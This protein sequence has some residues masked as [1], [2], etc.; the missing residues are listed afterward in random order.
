M[1]IQQNVENKYTQMHGI[2]SPFNGLD[3]VFIS[4]NLDILLL[5]VMN[6]VTLMTLRPLLI[7]HL[8]YSTVVKTE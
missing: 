6:V 3:I 8:L 2:H 7:G 5:I 4:Q 1:L